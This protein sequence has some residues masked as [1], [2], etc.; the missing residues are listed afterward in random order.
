MKINMIYLS[1]DE[2]ISQWMN[3][4]TLTSTLNLLEETKDFYHLVI[5][6][7]LTGIKL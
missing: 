7:I 6:P 5:I 1:M 2:W 3:F 4:A